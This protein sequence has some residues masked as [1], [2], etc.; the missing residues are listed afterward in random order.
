[1]HKILRCAAFAAVLALQ[2]TGVLA[3]NRVALVIGN[4]DY[5]NVPKLQKAVNDAKAIAKKLKSLG[6]EVIEGIDLDRRGMVDKIQELDFKIRTGDDVVIYYAGHGVEINDRNYLLP[7]DMRE[8]KPGQVF[9]V[10][11][12]AFPAEDFL[13]VASQHA[14]QITVLILDA[15]RN[16]PFNSRNTRSL[17]GATRGLA[18]VQGPEGTFIL[19][20]AGNGQTALDRLD[21][22]DSNPNSVFTRKLLPLMSKPGMSVTSLARTVRREVRDLARSVQHKQRP[23]YYDDLIGDFYLVEE[24]ELQDGTGDS[25]TRAA[26]RT[27]ASVDET[28]KTN[29]AVEERLFWQSIENS[30]NS[31]PFKVYLEAFPNGMFTEQAKAK[32]AVLDATGAPSSDTG[33][34]GNGG[35]ASNGSGSSG[36]AG[37]GTTS[38]STG[39]AENDG[40]GDTG[41]GGAASENSSSGGSGTSTTRSLLPAVSALPAAMA[42]GAT[43]LAQ[44]RRVREDIFPKSSAIRL[45]D[46]LL[47]RLNC[48]KL[49]TARNEIYH[50][51]GYC[52]RT[53]LGI[54]HFGNANCKTI[55]QDI[56]SPLE[57]LNV[58]LIR[59]WEKRRKCD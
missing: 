37:T 50:R 24:E 12:E 29:Q 58:L 26:G 27:V 7:T 18:P 31:A 22:N 11:K 5:Q 6:F 32:I 19:Y 25:D 9:T 2:A 40:S 55:R 34:S 21:E 54:Q 42:N 20:A 46:E 28:A 43:R 36:D 23:A 39:S 56:L 13:E 59:S 10:T 8:V 47:E 53:R 52:F 57:K 33:A 14:A 51:N 30:D 44:L 3:G 15:C 49:W 1:M 38:G 48:L 17:I 35:S 4:N 45:K 41:A 16:N